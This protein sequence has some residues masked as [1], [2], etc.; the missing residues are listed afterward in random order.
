MK[1]K[2]EMREDYKKKNFRAGI[3]QIKN[4]TKNKILLQTTFDLDKAFNSD[5]FQLNLGVH[6]KRELQKD[7]KE[8]GK[9]GFEFS[10]FDE[11][12]SDETVSDQ[13][14]R[15]DLKDLLEIHTLDLKSQGIELY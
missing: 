10:I 5:I 3:F 13:Q 6:T 1:T 15:Q 11:L 7:W 8:L 9:D 2:K 4:K 12:K 14:L